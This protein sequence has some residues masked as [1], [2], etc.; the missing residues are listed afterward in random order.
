[1]DLKAMGRVANAA[2]RYAKDVM[3]VA[4]NTN[5]RANVAEKAGASEIVVEPLREAYTLLKRAEALLEAAAE[6]AIDQI[7]EHCGD[8]GCPDCN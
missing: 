8:E 4:A 2:E 3:I 5:S 1:M 6:R 7:D